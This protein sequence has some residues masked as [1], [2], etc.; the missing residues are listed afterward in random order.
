MGTV[1]AIAIHA[2]HSAM[3]SIGRK[4]SHGASVTR[5]HQARYAGTPSYCHTYSSTQ[6]SAEQNT[7]C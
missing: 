6:S 2:G 3:R 5:G 4:L 1:T 7:H